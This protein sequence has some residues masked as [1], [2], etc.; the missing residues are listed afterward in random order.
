MIAE[1]QVM[2]GVMNRVTI[3]KLRTLEDYSD[4]FKRLR[5]AGFHASG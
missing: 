4:K 3:N 1:N 5:M 2:N